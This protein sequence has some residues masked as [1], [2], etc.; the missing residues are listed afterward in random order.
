MIIF[1]NQG[2]KG[3]TAIH[4]AF[5]PPIKPSSSEGASAASI[6]L[7]FVNAHLAAFDEMA[8]K[9]NTDFHDLSKRLS[10]DYNGIPQPPPDSEGDIS[11]GPRPDLIG[12]EPSSQLLSIYE[13]DV[14]F[15]MVSCFSDENN[16]D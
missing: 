16:C 7:T 5:T 1:F 15:W 11:A 4:L 9:R 3:G 10:F 6:N 12:S 8:E 14:L 13:T 2:N